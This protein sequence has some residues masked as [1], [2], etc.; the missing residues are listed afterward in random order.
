MA[1][2]KPEGQLLD[3]PENRHYLGSLAGLEEACAQG[4]ILE[5]RALVCDAGHNLIVDLGTMRGIIPRTE[6]AMGIEEGSTRDIAI[7]SRVN[8]PVCFRVTGFER[9]EDGSICPILSRRLVQ[10][11]CLEEYV[12]TLTPGQIV[13]VRVAHLESFGA[14]VDIG[15]GVPSLIPIDY[16]SISRIAH[17]GDR[18]R[19]GQDIKAVV[20]RIDGARI[21]LSHKELLGTW[22]ENA[23]LFAPGETV[24]GVVRSVEG[25]GTF[26]ELTPNLAGLAEHREGVLPGQQASVYIKSLLPERM[27]VKLIIVDAFDA[28]YQL[29]P[30][31]YFLQSG[32]LERWVYSPPSSPRVVETVFAE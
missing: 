23:A 31:R 6:G 14:F 2:Y 17:P 22:E 21:T 7:I 8:K 5:A 28:Q 12:K 18:F 25:Y 15:C 30:P 24:S 16:I 4:R 10:E 32:K 26:V 1:I 19:P 27:K 11:Q 3:T 20:R 29:P 13:D 9:S